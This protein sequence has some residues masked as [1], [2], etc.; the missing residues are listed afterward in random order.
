[1]GKPTIFVLV[2]LLFLIPLT[3]Q[4]QDSSE[5]DILIDKGIGYERENKLE[6]SIETYR[7]IIEIDPDNELVRVR[8]AKVLS[9]THRYEEALVILDEVLA[10]NPEQSE[11]LFRKAQILS[12][13]GQYGE[14]IELYEA[15]LRQEPDQ[16]D[17]LMGLARVYFW[18]GRNDEAIVYFQ[19][20]IAAGADQVDVHINMAKVYLST[21]NNDAAEEELKLALE[22]DPDNE[23][24]KRLMAGIER[25]WRYELMP[26]SFTFYVFPDKTVAYELSTSFTYHHRQ[27]WDFIGAYE[28]VTILDFFDHTLLFTTVFMGVPRLY[29]VGG[30]E[31][32]PDAQF[33][34]TGVLKT[35]VNY[36]FP[37]S[38]GAGVAFEA[39]FWEEAPLSTIQNDELYEI[40]PNV[41][42][43]FGDIS[44]VSFSYSEYIFGS[45]YSTR[46]AGIGTTL[47][48]Y[49]ENTI[50]AGFSYGGSVEIKDK[51]RRVL[52]IG[53]GLGIRMSRMFYVGFS[54][55]Y[56]DTQYGQTNQ[57]SILPV[58]RW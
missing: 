30:F 15:Y 27:R 24:A 23:E 9:W 47:A 39:S 49:K 56:I 46:R 44:N 8:L 45:G 36:G 31:F 34:P 4:A 25:L 57:I 14:S 16:P 2:I 41:T 13:E 17:G 54:Y 12:W 7:Q 37:N 22:L 28:L 29:L 5:I 52:E 40:R 51:A 38:I 11:A 33:S 26:P 42:R 3:L 58:I 35:S 48:F 10:R 53:L 6:E 18:S 32:T 20:S 21:G 55:E 50:S 19:R 43:Y 1:M